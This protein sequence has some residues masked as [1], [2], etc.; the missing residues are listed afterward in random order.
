MNVFK[1]LHPSL[2]ETLI[3]GLGWDMLRPVQEKSCEAVSAGCDIIILAPTAGGKTEAAFL[4]VL[5]A[6]LKRP[7]GHL[8][9]VYISPLKALINDQTDRIIDLGQ[10]AGLETAVQHGDVSAS[11]R[12]NFS[13]SEPDILLT[14]PE[15]LEVLLSSPDSCDA[16]THLRFIIVDEIHAFVESSRGVHLKCLID[17]LTHISQENPQRIGLSAT[18]GNPEFLLEWFSAPD[19]KKTLV[20]VPAPPSK[21]HFTFILERNFHAAAEKTAA[22]VR[23]KKA[24]IFVDSRSFAERLYQ[25]LS[26]LLPQVYLHH[27]AVSSSDRKEA[28]EAFSSDG[29]TCVICTST[30]ELGIDI[31]NLDLVVNFGPPLSASSF[32]QRLGRTGRRGKPAEMVFILKDSCELLTAAAAVEAAAAHKS[33]CLIPPKNPYDVL[34][35]QLFLLIKSRRAVSEPALI[36]ALKRLSPFSE[37][38]ESKLRYLLQYLTDTG[39]LFR[40]GSLLLFGTRA[41]TEFGHANWKALL[42]VLSDSGGYTAVLPDGTVVGTLDPR[43]VAGDAGKVF[44]FTG[45]TWRLLFRDDVH[46]RALIEPSAVSRGLKHPFWG[47]AGGSARVSRLAAESA[48]GIIS[49]GHSVLPLPSDVCDAL[50]DLLSSL[51]RGIKPGKIHLRVEPEVET[52]DV[53]ISTF[54]GEEINR[55]LS[56]LLKNRLIP[57]LELRA[58]PFA[59]RVSGFSAKESCDTVSQ[60][61]YEIAVTSSAV[62]SEELP[63]IPDVSVKFSA[64]LPSDMKKEMAVSYYKLDELLMLLS[65]SLLRP[66]SLQS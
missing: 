6:L 3:T 13:E 18:V 8:S 31:G 28:E 15:S 2:Q 10:R 34:L 52:W 35:Q 30:M 47:G 58:T 66:D 17:R 14:T 59:V 37:I 44:S 42:S 21:K 22:A 1:E 38:P 50:D 54:A 5:D 16:F 60:A 55:V 51:P 7:T 20:S 49:R 62:L 11:D 57:R 61:L 63:E 45:K 43:F 23:G 25:P 27:S 56:L 33:E 64:A 26:E 12:W 36:S 32:L 40:D 24:L 65:D 19:R 4:P 41:E 53:V 39:Y 9:A 29:G 46:R 48:G